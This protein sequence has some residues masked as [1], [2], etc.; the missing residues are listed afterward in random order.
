[1]K[2]KWIVAQNKSEAQAP[3]NCTLS[4]LFEQKAPI[5]FPHSEWDQAIT[6]KTF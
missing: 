1:M 5:F 2:K 6:F 4:A 3:E